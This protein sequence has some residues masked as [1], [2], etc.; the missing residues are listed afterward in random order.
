MNSE[1]IPEPD[2]RVSKVAASSFAAST[3]AASSDRSIAEGKELVAESIEIEV[4]LNPEFDKDSMI[5]QEN[6]E[7]EKYILQ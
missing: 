6:K 2:T 4:Y 3:V 5:F 1:D 7:G